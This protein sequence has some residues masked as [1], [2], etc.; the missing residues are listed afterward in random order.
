MAHFATGK[1]LRKRRDGLCL[2]FFERRLVNSYTTVVIPFDD[3]VIF[4]NLPNC[5]EFSRRYSEV[6]QSL[7][8][9]SGTQFLASAGRF[10]QRWLLGT[11]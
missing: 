2:H 5:A 11:V 8:A 6:A 7:D 10:D 4:V 3:R 9:I 1:G